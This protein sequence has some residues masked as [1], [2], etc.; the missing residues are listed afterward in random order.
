MVLPV[1]ETE[2]LADEL[3]LAADAVGANPALGA[4]PGSHLLGF[5]A[6]A[7]YGDRSA[8]MVRIEQAI[9]ELWGARDDAYMAAWR[10]ADMEG[11][12]LDVLAHIW[13]GADTV[14][15]LGE[16][17]KM[18]QTPD[19]I[20]SSLT[21]LVEREYA[22]RDGDSVALTPTGVMAR[23]DIE[24]ETDRVYFDGWPYG[25]EEA[26]WVKEKLAELVEGLA[27]LNAAGN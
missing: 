10:A 23:E 6:K 19:D 11:P 24:N 21:W 26:L 22:V 17:L 15:A 2:R 1:E 18:K 14:A 13:S 16:A 8:P 27:A 9:G 3:R 12:P 25:I 7:R 20:E 5:Q 4:S